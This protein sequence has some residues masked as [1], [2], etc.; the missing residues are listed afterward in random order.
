MTTSAATVTVTSGASDTVRFYGHPANAAAGQTLP[1]VK[2]SI[3]SADGGIDTTSSAAVT[4]F[5]ASGP[6]T[7][8]GGTLPVD[9]V[10]GI[11]TFSNLVLTDPGTYTFGATSG[12]ASSDS[13][14]FTITAGAV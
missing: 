7:T 12:S 4:I 9:A 11:A 2:V 3:V 8:L 6:T 1:P 14:A 5:V 10:D 13:T